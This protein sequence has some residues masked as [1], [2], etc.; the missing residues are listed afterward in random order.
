MPEMRLVGGKRAEV[1]K[2]DIM[3]FRPL[4]LDPFLSELRRRPVRRRLEGCG[5]LIFD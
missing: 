5:A 2:P 3:W 1:F 4:R